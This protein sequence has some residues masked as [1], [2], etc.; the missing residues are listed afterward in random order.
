MKA[1]LDL[2]Q[3]YKWVVEEDKKYPGDKDAFVS[4]LIP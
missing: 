2:N 1:G 4:H 3:F